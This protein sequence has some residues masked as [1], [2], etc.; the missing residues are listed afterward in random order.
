MG[1]F[2]P[3]TYLRWREPRLIRG[4]LRCLEE[5][6]LSP[7]T[8]PILALVLAALLLVNWAVAKLDP[9]KDPWT[10]TVALPFALG[11]GLVFVYAF[12]WLYRI[13]P[14]EVRVHEKGISRVVGDDVQFWKYRDITECGVCSQ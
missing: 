11:G 7:F 3:T 5:R 6:R 2:I 8:R 4:R 14:A 9:Q 12:P 10:L 1:R 13:C